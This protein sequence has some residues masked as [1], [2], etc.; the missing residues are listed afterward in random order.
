MVRSRRATAAVVG[1]IAGAAVT[2]TAPPALAASEPNI[3]AVAGV[4][5]VPYVRRSTDATW[6][7]LGGQVDGAPSVATAPNGTTYVVARAVNHVLY[8]RT[9][10]S[11]WV[12]L[13]NTTNCGVPAV[14]ATRSTL[15]VACRGK[16]NGALYIG[17]APL[18]RPF[19]STWVNGG[20]QL[21][22]DPSVTVDQYDGVT[23]WV[24]GPAHSQR[25][26]AWYRSLAS[27]WAPVVGRT[28]AT[29]PSALS[30]E[31][32]F[33]FVCANP[34]GD[35]TY[36]LYIEG[37]GYEDGDIPA[38]ITSNVGLAISP[39]LESVAVYAQGPHGVIYKTELANTGSPSFVR[40]GGTAVGGAG[41]ATLLPLRL[42]S[43]SVPR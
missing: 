35:L 27:G 11:G 6:T 1:V 9:L 31:S 41:A 13:S 26:N 43:S 19:I 40:V 28:C 8:V 3:V 12:R 4:N 15:Y 18:S 39:N 17:S 21:A 29:R 23:F 2:S 33:V 38:E 14:G 32:V 5:H 22:S 10:T 7:N 34:Q 30:E 25:G 42:A 20:G 16:S 36:E 37:F 24:V